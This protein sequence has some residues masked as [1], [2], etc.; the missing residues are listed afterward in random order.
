VVGKR[1][2]PGS[3][4]FMQYR[5][6]FQ[7]HVHAY[8]IVV[9]DCGSDLSDIAELEGINGFEVGNG[10]LIEIAH[11]VFMGEPQDPQQVVEVDLGG[12]GHKITETG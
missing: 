1:E 9:D 2:K 8:H 4:D 10:A 6:G 7:F 3:P 5:D 11:V 12:W